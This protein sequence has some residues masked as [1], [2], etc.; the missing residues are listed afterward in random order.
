MT[1]QI[2]V[3]PIWWVNITSVCF[4]FSEKKKTIDVAFYAQC[5]KKNNKYLIPNI[6]TM[7]DEH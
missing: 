6:K 4:H 1:G 3:R 7:I 5:K 2:T